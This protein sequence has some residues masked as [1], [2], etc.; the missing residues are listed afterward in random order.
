MPGLDRISFGYHGDDGKLFLDTGYPAVTSS[1]FGPEGQY[2]TTDTVGIGLNMDSGEGFVTLN[3]A[4]M[5]VGKPGS[6]R[7]NVC[8]S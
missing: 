6:T 7:M 5:D 1:D 3:G 8:L 2:S 4:K